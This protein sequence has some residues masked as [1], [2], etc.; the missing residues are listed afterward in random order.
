[1]LL[2][3]CLC[4]GIGLGAAVVWF[5]FFAHVTLRVATGP[6]GSDGQK[7]LAAFVRSVADAHHRVRLQ[8]VPMGDREARTK[9]LMAGDVDLAVV[10]SDDLTSPTAQTIAI[11]RRDVV[12]LVIPPYA[13]L[14]KVGQLAGKTIGLLQGP[15]GD[16]RILDQILSYYQVPTQRVHRVVLAPGEIG[17]AVRQ[18]RVAAIFAIGPAGPGV[19]ADVVTAVAKVS[20]EAPDILEIEAAE[21]IAQRFPVLEE[22]EIAPGA[23]R[24]VPLRPEESVITLAVTLRLVARS[25][26]PNYVASEVARLLF[27]AKAT[28]ASTLPQMGQIEAP[29]TDKGAALPVHPGAAAYFDGEQ[30][31]LLEQFGTYAYLVAIIGSVIGA[32]YA[33]M[34]SAWR[35]AGRQ[36]HEQLLRLLAMLRN[37][38]SVDLDTLEAFDKEAEA[39]NTWALERVTQEAMEAEQFLVFSQ[40]V[41]QVWQAIDRQRARRH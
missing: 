36:E 19:L 2:I 11:L 6:V 17:P 5:F 29:D 28:L 16:E 21:A 22:V 18:K 27:A 25:S 40:V 20:R 15:A 31:S 32:G 1:M 3:A 12:G 8:I 38:S 9:A 33:W 24:T 26:M 37:I 39:I 30:T 4:V 23:F 41:T 35:D 7:L 34:R 14:E 10:R 13:L